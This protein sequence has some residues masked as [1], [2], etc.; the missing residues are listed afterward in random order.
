M[1]LITVRRAPFGE[2]DMEMNGVQ[3][4]LVRFADRVQLYP[5]LFWKT[6]TEKRDFKAPPGS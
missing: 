1:V 6:T 4:E 3:Q 2:A 5:K